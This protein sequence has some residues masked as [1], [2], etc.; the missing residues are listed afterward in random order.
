MAQTCAFLSAG[1]PRGGGVGN[2]NI[3]PYREDKLLERA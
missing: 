1:V 2:K 3:D